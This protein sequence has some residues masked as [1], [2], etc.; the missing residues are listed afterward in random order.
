MTTESQSHTGFGQKYS[1]VNFG[2]AW[3]TRKMGISLFLG[4]P[5]KW[6]VSLW[7]L[8]KAAKNGAPSTKHTQMSNKRTGNS[9]GQ[10][11]VPR[12]LN[13]FC[14]VTSAKPSTS[15][16]R[17]EQG[18]AEYIPKP[19]ALQRNPRKPPAAGNGDCVQS[20]HASFEGPC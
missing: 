2:A 19:P 8:F 3:G 16:R 12:E 1:N 20:R 13:E 11:Q 14:Y 18:S 9:L 10:T 6:W 7:F 4:D 15:M 5:P 17:A